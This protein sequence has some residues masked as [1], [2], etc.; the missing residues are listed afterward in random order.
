MGGG[1][2]GVGLAVEVGGVSGVHGVRFGGNG[3]IFLRAVSIFVH[4]VELVEGGRSV[5][6]E[7]VEVL[8]PQTGRERP[9]GGCG[10]S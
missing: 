3:G 4:R 8:V 10:A 1:F 2:S 9:N 5:A 7:C 6:D